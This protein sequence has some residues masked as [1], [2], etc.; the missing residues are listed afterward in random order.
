[1]K[2]LFEYIDYRKYLDSFYQ[3]KKKSARAFSYRYFA[4]KA[5]I[6]SPSFLK[7]V[8]D[9][10]RNLSRRMIEKFSR[11]LGLSEKE[12]L[13]FRNLVLFNQ[14]ATSSEK[15]EYYGNLRAMF[16]T[17]K[18]TVLN[19]DQYDYFANWYTPVVRELIC[20]YNFN[21]NYKQIASMLVPQILP[22]EARE[23]VKLL[24][25]LK[26]VRR[27][28]AGNYRQTD[29]AISADNSIL[30]MAMRSFAKTMIEHSRDAIDTIDWR[31]RHIS[32]VTVG[33]SPATFDV[34]NAE[35][36]AF[37][38]RMKRI[39]NRDNVNNQV[40]QMNISLFP[41]TDSTEKLPQKKA[42]EL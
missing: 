11:G 3:H 2:S 30:S 33:I 18:E 26:M 14:S 17:V 19:T 23:A 42:K 20:Q 38:D 7:E 36:E 21:D 28:G 34:L 24:L 15:Q 9:G 22:S 27:D 4:Q 16:G 12:S 41:V 39:V 5:G 1:M 35:I 25:R 8:I 10:K 40:Y 6:H 29:T 37:K 32:T 31:I 13:Y